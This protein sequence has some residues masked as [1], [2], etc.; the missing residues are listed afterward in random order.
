M[1]QQEMIDFI[2]NDLGG[3]VSKADVHRVLAGAAA[4]VAKTIA[5]GTE[6]VVP[7]VGV[8]KLATL[9]GRSGTLH[10]GPAAGTKFKTRDRV[11]PRM[12]F[13]K[14]IRAAAARNKPTK[15]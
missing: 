13:N 6:C 8:V 3:R 11:K 5:K 1:K 14:A 4:R 7:G 15:H 2:Y 10:V 9:K 12:V